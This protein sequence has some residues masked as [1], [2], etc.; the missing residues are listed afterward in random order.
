[1]AENKKLMI[2]FAITEE[3]TLLGIYKLFFFV[4]ECIMNHKFCSSLA[5]Y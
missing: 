4:I 1:M 2:H 5:Y 3:I